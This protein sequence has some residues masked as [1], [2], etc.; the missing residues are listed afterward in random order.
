M[1]GM[2][3]GGGQTDLEPKSDGHWYLKSHQNE[4][5]I[6]WWLL[7]ELMKGRIYGYH[8]HFSGIRTLKIKAFINNGLSIYYL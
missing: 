4:N 5:E 3:K 2:G 1:E 7:S 6:A 8:L